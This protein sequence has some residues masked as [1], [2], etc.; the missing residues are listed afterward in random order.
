MIHKSSV[1]AMD[2]F[3]LTAEEIEL[4]RA[5]NR[6]VPL[7]FPVARANTVHL[8]HILR[9]HRQD[10]VGCHTHCVAID[11][12]KSEDDFVQV[13]LVPVPG[14]PQSRELGDERARNFS[15]GR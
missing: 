8:S 1:S 2:L 11:L 13:A 12:M 3:I 10:L 5:V 6:F 4:A 9:T 15:Q 14:K 7:A